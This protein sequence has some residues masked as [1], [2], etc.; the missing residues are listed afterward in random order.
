TRLKTLLTENLSGLGGSNVGGGMN[1]LTPGAV[2][3]LPEAI[4]TPIV[5]SYNEALLPIFLFLVPLAVIA[6]IVLAFVQEKKLAT[7]VELEITAESLAEGQLAPMDLTGEPDDDGRP[8]AGE[9]RR[10]N[11]A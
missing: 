1:S 7:N 6:V 4:R 2:N 9:D 3:D 5:E 8:T 11:H 10:P